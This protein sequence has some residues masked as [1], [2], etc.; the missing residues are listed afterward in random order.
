MLF[1]LLRVG[2][3]I[4]A[5]KKGKLCACPCGSRRNN[6]FFGLWADLRFSVAPRATA[7]VVPSRAEGSGMGV[8]GSV[9]VVILINNT[10]SDTPRHNPSFV[11]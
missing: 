10:E 7:I 3:S 5:I 6:Y 9:L 4:L 2:V 11:L 1:I 8:L